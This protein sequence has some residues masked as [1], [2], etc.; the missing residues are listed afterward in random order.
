LGRTI[1]GGSKLSKDIVFKCDNPK[2]K[3][4]I[5]NP[6]LDTQSNPESWYTLGYFYK[7]KFHCTNHYCSGECL[8]KSVHVD[9]KEQK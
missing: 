4:V 8:D 3:K 6:T 1:I 7:T 9:E 5:V 2:C